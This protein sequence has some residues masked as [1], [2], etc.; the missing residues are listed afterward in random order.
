MWVW[1]IHTTDQKSRV[2]NLETSIFIIYYML[3]KD[4][5]GSVERIL[6]SVNDIRE[7]E[8]LPEKNK[9]KTTWQHDRFLFLNL[10]SAS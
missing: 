9:N 4:F 2:G 1:Q 8:Q 5:P 6:H 3:K 10:N 7:G